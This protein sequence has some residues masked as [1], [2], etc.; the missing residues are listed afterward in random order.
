MTPGTSSTTASRRPRIRLTR[1]DFPTLGRPRMAR[2][3]SWAE[4]AT[5]SMSDNSVSISPNSARAAAWAASASAAS[6][7][8][9]VD[10]IEASSTCHIETESS[11]NSSLPTDGG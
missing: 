8:A 5:R 9:A 11:P 6:S 1:V 2:V 10:V 4:P 3:G 7:P